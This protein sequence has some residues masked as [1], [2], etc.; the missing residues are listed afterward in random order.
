[1][2]YKG[3][4]DD[5][6]LAQTADLVVD[7]GGAGDLV[8]RAHVLPCHPQHLEIRVNG[9]VVASR[10]VC[11]GA[12]SLRL[13]VP[14]SRSDRHVELKW[15]GTAR[16]NDDDPREAAALLQSLQVTTQQ[17]PT[18]LRIPG[19]LSHPG[20][21]HSGIYADGWVGQDARLVL[22]GGGDATLVVRGSVPERLPSQH[23]TLTVGG[24]TVVDADAASGAFEFRAPIRASASERMVEMRWRAVDRVSS[25]DSRSAA[26]LLTFVGHTVGS[27]PRAIAHF[28]DDLANPNLVQT[29]IYPDGWT[30][31]RAVIDLAGGDAAEL[32]IR[33]DV[34][35]A[36]RPQHVEVQVGTDVLAM[37]EAAADEIDV[38]IR[39]PTT[40]GDRS[41][42]LRWAQD[43]PVSESDPR[44]AAA[45]L[46][47]IGL[48]SGTLPN[49]IARFPSDLLNPNLVH[50][51]I[52]ADGW[53]AQ[54]SSAL[55]VGGARAQ[56]KLLAHVPTHLSQQALDVLV[57]GAIVASV[58]RAAGVV[59]MRVDL[60]QSD[61]A[62]LIVLRWARAEPL[63]AADP[64][65][66]A[67]RLDLIAV[68]RQRGP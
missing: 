3:I 53:L 52:Y 65:R 49:A 5:G 58:K 2:E 7:G 11:E 34:P 31:R 42:E 68:T 35:P 39:V 64:R 40:Q 32:V 16:L 60:V 25:A 4:Y 18:A 27:A 12:L 44:L 1:M 38:R 45:R 28:P 47:F 17:P 14:A 57:D 37:E 59:D 61:A 55:L 30:E 33:A 51:G 41:I 23:L 19:G 29:G 54:E 24:E 26:A 56:L 10:D 46:T 13:P 48:A 63:S 36:L 21:W 67:A 15:A 62:R 43:G 66:A 8:L 20:A 6:W 22:A 50:S 9:E